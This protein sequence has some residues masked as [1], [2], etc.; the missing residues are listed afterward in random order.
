MKPTILVLVFVVAVAASPWPWAAPQA[1][2]V[3]TAAKKTPNRTKTNRTR[4]NTHKEPT[5][6]F[7]AP[8]ECDTPI[9]PVNLLDSNEVRTTG[10]KALPEE[11]V[12]IKS[13]VVMADGI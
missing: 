3:N 4:K 8:C 2:L 9:V 13:W 1:D 12:R 5:P 11:D 10:K 6:I 7:K